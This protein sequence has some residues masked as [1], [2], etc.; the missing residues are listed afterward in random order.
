MRATAGA[1]LDLLGNPTRREILHLIADG[2]KYFTELSKE[3][4]VRKM[5]IERHIRQLEELGVISSEEEKVGRGRPRKY[6]EITTRA[7]LKVKISPEIFE[8]KYWTWGESM[9]NEGRNESLAATE[10]IRDP[11]DRLS[12]LSKI[13]EKVSEDIR[14][15]EE[16]IA[17]DEELL[18]RIKRAGA[19]ALKSMPLE[20]MEKR[21][22][23]NLLISG[24]GKRSA[25][26]AEEIG[27]EPSRVRRRLLRMKNRDLLRYHH[28]NWR[29]R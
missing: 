19:E 13:A 2:P 18:E 23:L 4:G 6:Y 8:T 25:E 10:G 17:R 26:V 12:A 1:I 28:H 16:A 7:K 24:K 29:I 14:M 3:T 21:L 20:P 22:L 27:E 5:A 15:H 9:G 11:V